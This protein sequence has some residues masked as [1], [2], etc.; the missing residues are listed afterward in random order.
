[1]TKRMTYLAS[2]AFL[3]LGALSVSNAQAKYVAIAEE[4]G[5]N[6]V[7]AGSGTFDLTDLSGGHGLDGPIQGFVDPDNA[8]IGIGTPQAISTAL[9]DIHP[10]S[11]GFGSGSGAIA[12]SGT[13]DPVGAEVGFLF[14]PLN[15]VSGAHLSGSSTYL[16][17]SFASLGMTPGEYVWTWGSGD[18]ADSFT[19]DVGG[20]IPPPAGVPEPSTWA[21]ML[22]GFAGLGYAAVR[23]KGAG[24][25][26]SA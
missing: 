5:P 14:G 4:E 16:G 1:M 18:H 6:V 2:A 10:P 23:R 20:V 25:A 9:G 8:A 12:S 3:A 17:Q 22:I 13:G 21:M 11:G 24:R 19:L 26:I 7:I 15:Y